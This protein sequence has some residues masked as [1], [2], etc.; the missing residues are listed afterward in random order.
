MRLCLS[1]KGLKSIR[2]LNIEIQA[3]KLKEKVVSNLEPFAKR[4]LMNQHKD[5]TNRKKRK[6]NYKRKTTFKL[7][8]GKKKKETFRLRNNLKIKRKE[9]VAIQRV[10]S[11]RMMNRRSFAIGDLGG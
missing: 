1:Q 2:D 7:L 10:L 3:E 4:R 9:Q 5:T 6:S 8:I 11:N